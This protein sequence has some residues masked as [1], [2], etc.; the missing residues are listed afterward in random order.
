MVH[1]G[2]MLFLP[3]QYV[4]HVC[5]FRGKSSGASSD[6]PPGPVT[7]KTPSL[8]LTCTLCGHTSPL[9]RCVGIGVRFWLLAL[10][11]EDIQRLI[12][13]LMSFSFVVTW[14]S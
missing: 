3:Y 5:L 2:L 4:F 8:I 9:H 11:V 7:S 1:H 14:N 10:M 13:L 12:V 6:D